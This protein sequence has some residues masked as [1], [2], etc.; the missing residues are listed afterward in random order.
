MGTP[1]VATDLA[2][3]RARRRRRRA[4]ALIGYGL[5]RALKT[6]RAMPIASTLTVVIAISTIGSIIGVAQLD[7]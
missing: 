2:H 1:P 6:R 5:Q 3:L 7:A 4:G